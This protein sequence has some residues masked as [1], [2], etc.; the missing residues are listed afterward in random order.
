MNDERH[1]LQEFMTGQRRQPRP[2]PWL[3]AILWFAIILLFGLLFSFLVDDFV[4]NRNKPAVPVVGAKA[5]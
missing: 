4:L 1:I 3:N 5:G 2:Q